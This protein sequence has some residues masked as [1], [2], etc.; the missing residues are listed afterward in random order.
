MIIQFGKKPTARCVVVTA[1]K[2]GRLD[3]FMMRIKTP[4]VTDLSMYEYVGLQQNCISQIVIQ[5]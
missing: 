5:H 4:P 1:P 2:N 3:Q